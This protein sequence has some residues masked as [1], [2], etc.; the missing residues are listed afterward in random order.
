MIW[1]SNHNSIYLPQLLP[2]LSA[3]SFDK[4]NYLSKLNNPNQIYSR[5]NSD[6][7]EEILE[8]FIDEKQSLLIIPTILNSKSFINIYALDIF[9]KKV[10]NFFLHHQKKTSSIIN[11][12]EMCSD[13]YLNYHHP[14]NFFANGTEKGEIQLWQL[15]DVESIECQ[16]IYNKLNHRPN[17]NLNESTITVQSN[18]NAKKSKINDLSWNKINK[19]LIISCSSNGSINYIDVN[20]E[21]SC[22]LFELKESEPLF[23]NCNPFN[24]FEYIA[25]LKN[26]SYFIADCRYKKNVTFINSN[27]QLEAVNW[28]SSDNFFFEIE[29][30]GFISLF[31]KRYI[32][33]SSYSNPLLRI[34]A[35][36]T[37]IVH[38]SLCNEFKKIALLDKKGLVVTWE[39][40]GHAKF[41]NKVKINNTKKK[42]KKIIWSPFKK[43]SNILM[44]LS[45]DLSISLLS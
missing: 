34:S 23:L 27:R 2:D 10:K 14:G 17:K 25:L 5:F 7:F 4:K 43:N 16:S 30:K 28:I 24:S 6:Y 40:T 38:S 45:E 15:E 13:N 41:F 21:K 12:M 39:L 44:L 42:A 19:N 8:N 37:D 22:N 20:T 36:S 1:I 33:K 35:L 32:K 31:D 3:V 26:S 9:D 29:K 11:C 18:K